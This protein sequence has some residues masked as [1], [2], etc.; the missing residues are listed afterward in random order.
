MFR[1]TGVVVYL[2]ATLAAALIVASAV[3]LFIDRVDGSIVAAPLA[4]LVVVVAFLYWTTTLLPGPVRRL[5]KAAGR[6]VFTS[7]R[8]RKRK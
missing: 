2:F 8:N 7:A 1:L 6:H 5:G 3:L 4:E